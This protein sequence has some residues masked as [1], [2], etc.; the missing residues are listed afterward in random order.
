MKTYLAPIVLTLLLAC[1]CGQQEK[2]T[3][4]KPVPPEEPSIEMSVTG[5]GGK[6]ALGD[7][8]DQAKKVFPAPKDGTVIPNSMSFTILGN[9]GWSWTTK[10]GDKGFEVQLQGGKVAAIAVTDMT[11][12]STLIK[13]AEKEWGKPTHRADGKT[14]MVESW[15]S[16][17]KA[18][19]AVST[20]MPMLGKADFLMVGKKA[21][22][23]LLSHDPDNPQAFIDMTEGMAETLR[24]VFEEAKRKA[25]EKAKSK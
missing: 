6:L 17:D 15:V 4:Q 14:M 11:D 24:P 22:L 1:G 7:S 21:D 18:R 20:T 5:P 8:L 19:M 10:A 13:D 2:Q 23:K 9:E 12:N 25:K 16:G 3:V